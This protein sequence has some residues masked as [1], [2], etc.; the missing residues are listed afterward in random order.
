VPVLE[1]TR[2]SSDVIA[3]NRDQCI[4]AGN[5]LHSQYVNAEPFPHIVIDDFLDKDV[6][7]N[8]LAEWPVAGRDRKYY[9]RAQERLKYEWQPHELNSPALRSFLAEM[10]ADPMVSFIS[11]LT[12]IKCL[13]A[14]PYYWG[15][16]LHEI[17]RGGHLGVHADFNIHSG[18]NTQR[19]VNL[20]IYLNENWEPE[21]GGQ[22]ELWARD[23]SAVRHK[24]LPK[25]G[26]A[27]VFNTDSDSFHGHPD[28]LT[29][30][31]DRSRRSIALY[32]YTAPEEG[33][34]KIT[35]RT[36]V[37]KPRPSSADK[38]DWGAQFQHFVRDWT[39]PALLRLA[40]GRRRT[41]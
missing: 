4:E 15:A 7:R 24:V 33:L 14:D 21:Y 36:T 13:I 22:L 30:P 37:F 25:I 8:L 2:L 32:Y 38:R 27:V 26:A 9:D 11:A 5:R 35:P 17:K 18:M 40:G 19:R 16:G 1:T 23:M 28:P 3:L 41:G 12:G 10:N 34:K 6:L 29:C 20:L 39:P 31:P